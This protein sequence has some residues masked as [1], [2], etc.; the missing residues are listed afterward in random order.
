[1]ALKFN[2]NLFDIAKFIGVGLLIAFL[3][4]NY[5]KFTSWMDRDKQD[6]ITPRIERLEEGLVRVAASANTARLEQLIGELKDQNSKA[7]AA[8]KKEGKKVDELTIVVTEMR[9][10][11]KMQ[12]G[13]EFD[14][15]ETDKPSTRDFV[16]TVIHRTDAKGEKLPMARIFF[17]PEVEKDPWT[18]QNFPLKLH[19]NILQVEDDSGVYESF[20]ETYFTNDFV[21]SS[22]GK[23]YYFDSNV[24]W[25]KREKKD[26]KFRLNFRLGFTGSV[27][28]ESVFP[29]LDISF[30]SYGR[31]KKD[32]DWR[33]LTT[34]I[35]YGDEDIFGYLYPVQYNIGGF[36]PLIENLHL[37]PLIG[38]DV[39]AERTYGVGMSVLF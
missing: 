15:P 18:V 6:L 13:D 14:D 5:G 9:A 10:E 27:A 35:G 17:H 1:M 39:K 24:S 34:G 3:W 16:D 32:S 30:F 7:L 20:V 19:T 22:K 26:K 36:I 29:G 37:G 31:T 23:K 8:L 4:F 28:T 11:S 38:V 21:K 25:A 2:T 12:S 33:F